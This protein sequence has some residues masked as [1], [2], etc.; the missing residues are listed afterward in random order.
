MSDAEKLEALKAFAEKL[1][2][3]ARQIYSTPKLNDIQEPRD[4][5]FVAMTILCRTL[6]HFHGVAWLIN[7]K[8]IVEARILT[9]CCFEN[10]FWIGALVKKGPAFVDEMERDDVASFKKRTRGWLSFGKQRNHRDWPDHS[11]E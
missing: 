5:K 7:Q 4:P 6:G 11:N 3:T 9:R 10:L 8:R 1:Y 2:V